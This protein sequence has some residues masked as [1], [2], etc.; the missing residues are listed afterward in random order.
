MGWYPR[1]GLEEG[2][3]I[4]YTWYLQAFEKQAVPSI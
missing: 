1:T 2:V 3:R 4:T